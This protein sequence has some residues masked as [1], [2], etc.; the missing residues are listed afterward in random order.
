MPVTNKLSQ[1]LT[2]RLMRPGMLAGRAMRGGGADYEDGIHLDFVHDFHYVKVPGRPPI[3][4][5]F[6]S[7]FN[8]TGDNLSYYRGANGLL[9]PSVTNKKRR[10]FDLLGNPLGLLIEGQRTNQ[11]LH[12]RDHT[13]A[14]WVKVT[15]TAAKDQVGEDGVANSASSLQATGAA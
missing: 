9:L 3:V 1:P 8:F 4:A 10:E 15:M 13:N 14:A 6:E 2:R 7:L 5:D 12:S 11:I